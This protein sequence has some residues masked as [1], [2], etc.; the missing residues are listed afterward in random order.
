MRNCAARSPRRST[1]NC[2][3]PAKG[4]TATASPFRLLSNRMHGCRPTREIETFSPHVNLLAVLYDLAP[5]SQQ[6]AIVE[7]VLAEKPLNT[8]PW[9]M[10][11]VFQAIDHAGLFDQYGTQQMRRWK[12]VKD[13]QSFHEMW[14]GGDL[15]HGWCS[16]P[17]VQM[18]QRVLGVTPTSPGFKTLAVRPRAL[19]SGLG[20]RQRA[21]APRGR[22]RVV[23]V[24]RRSIA[25]G[26]DRSA[27]RRGGRHSADGAFRE[28][29][30]ADEWPGGQTGGSRV[31]RH[32]AIRGFRQVEG[33]RCQGGGRRACLGACDAFESDVVQNDL[34]RA[35][36]S[37]GRG[38]LHARRR[39]HE[40]R[41]LDQRY[42]TQ[43]R[44][45]RRHGRRW[46][47]VPRLRPGR[48]ADVPLE[49]GLQPQRDPY[50][51]RP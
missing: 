29:D 47:D 41:R 3:W 32:V 18:S 30:G 34:L 25:D 12:I 38:S 45:R 36:L 22:G 50:F 4:S 13:T 17:L 21:D 27:G 24:G 28:C 37:H 40:C 51:R 46:Q 44:R 7:K 23:E 15:S 6:A 1:A 5:K 2:G 9:F 35:D 10:H 42:D 48:L 14:N 20:K 49:A 11:W 26:R 39:R 19:R 31:C 43:R 8:Q 33:P 16:T